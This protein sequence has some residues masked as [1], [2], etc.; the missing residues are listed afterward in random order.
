MEGLFILLAIVITILPLILLIWFKVSISNMINDVSNKLIYLDNK[1]DN[2]IKNKDES[3]AVKP[4]KKEAVI[5]EKTPPIIEKVLPIKENIEEIGD[6]TKKTKEELMFMAKKAIENKHEKIKLMIENELNRRQELEKEK[7]A[8]QKAKEEIP[9][10]RIIEAPPMHK[11]KPENNKPKRDW[12]KFIGENLLNKIGIGILVL[13]IA[14]FVKYAIDKNWIGE[15]A[16]VAIGVVSGGLLTF[17][18]HKMRKTYQAFSSVL[19]GGGMAIFYFTIAIGFHEYGIFSQPVAFGLMVAITAFSILLSITYDRKELA[20]L[21]LIGA[22]STPIMLSDGSGNYKILFTYIAIINIGMLV[23]ALFKKWNIVNILSFAFT[24]ILYG[25]WYIGKVVN[26]ATHEYM[27][28]FF[29]ATLFYLIFIVMNTVNNVLK[30]RRFKGYEFGLLLANTSLYYSIGMSVLYLL[31]MKQYQGLFTIIL[32]AFNIIIT[33]PL[34]KRKNVDRSLIYLLIGMV[35]TFV[36]LAGP[37]QLSGNYITL[38]WATEMVL[39]LW[40]SQ[41][42]GIKFMKLGSLIIFGLMGISLVMDWNNIYM[43]YS[44]DQLPIVINKGFI[45]TVFALAGTLVYQLVLKK[46]KDTML[47]KGIS[48]KTIQILTQVV[49]GVLIYLAGILEIS[50]Q[51]DS[52][53]HYEALSVVALFGYTYLFIVGLAYFGKK[54]NN[55]PLQKGI[56]IVAVLSLISYLFVNG[57]VKEI[58]LDY[59]LGE[60]YLSAFFI[61]YANLALIGIL[62]YYIINKVK[63]W[64]TLNSPTGK[65]TV[66]AM[67]LFGLIV[68]SMQIDHHVVLFFSEMSIEG[69][70]NIVDNS[71]ILEQS[72]KIAYPIAWGLGSF[73]LMLVGMRHKYKTLRIVSLSIFSVVLLKLFMYDIQDAS[74]GG[75]IAAFISLGVL[76]LI[77][78]FMYQ[79]LKKLIIDDD[80][81]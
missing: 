52:R 76:L 53:A 77:V 31:D 81:K 35:L 65:M 71:S 39:L 55:V 2:I 13:G 16:R 80:S 60:S 68:A 20:I 27:G 15:V 62:S 6:L 78:S 32:A 17:L 7:I 30:K 33:I 48:L 67:S 4:I 37:V 19:V 70:E 36:S 66:W 23:L 1:I 45:T 75:K 42:S 28:A 51:I 56:V 41:K 49:V 46:E 21:A 69:I 9:V 58:R 57:S 34:F 47:F 38:F 8:A 64:N 44:P 26:G 12:E 3:M 10:R 43:D 54:T 40:L 74:E 59:F 63:E 24:V 11:K 50:Y 73:V 22:F 14:Y 25:S 29:F 5:Q 72:R 79:K 61:Q 18:A